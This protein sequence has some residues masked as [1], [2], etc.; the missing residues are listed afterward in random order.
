[1]LDGP[2]VKDKVSFI[3]GART[4]YSDWLLGMLSDERLKKSTAGF[5]D[6]QGTLTADINKKN[7]ISLSGTT[8]MTG[9]IITLRAVSNTAIPP[10]PSN[11]STHSVRD[12]T[13]QYFAIISNY[14][15]RLTS[16]ADSLD[17]SNTYYNLS[18][19]IGRADFTFLSSSKTG[20]NSALTQPCILLNPENVNRW[21]TGRK[22][23]PLSCRA[24]EPWNR[25]CISATSLK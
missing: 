20:W 19:K 25:L 23:S 13:A 5:Y 21:P 4:T 22:P 11:G 1:M 12:F 8:V 16:S 6:L 9:L 7:S 18:Q 3:I 14:S 2:L 15:Y 17:A 24:R 10:P